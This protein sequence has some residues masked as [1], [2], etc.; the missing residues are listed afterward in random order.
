[1][2]ADEKIK[3]KVIEALQLRHENTT[4]NF[5]RLIKCMEKADTVEEI[6]RLK[7]KILNNYLDLPLSPLTCYFCVEPQSRTGF[8]DFREVCPTCQYGLQ[9]GRCGMSNSDYDIILKLRA[10]L[11]EAIKK[12]FYN[13]N[14]APRCPTCGTILV[15]KVEKS[16]D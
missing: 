9:H 8:L 4:L 14:Y 1:M 13:E 7:G 12:A 16:D 6:M 5:N 3:E 2:K 15:E 10:K 11:V